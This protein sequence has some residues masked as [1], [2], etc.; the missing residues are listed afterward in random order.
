[1]IHQI[2]DVLSTDCR[3]CGARVPLFARFCPA[4]EAQNPLHKAAIAGAAALALLLAGSL[5]ALTWHALRTKEAP[6]V[7]T[8]SPPA[9]T[10][11]APADSASDYGWLVQAMADCEEEGK[12]LP[13]TLS[14]LIVPL[15]K[16]DTVLPGW[17]PVPIGTA[18][19][20][21]VLLNSTDA[22]IGLRNSALALYEK[23]LAFTVSDQTTSTVYKWKPAVG[24]SALKTRAP[25]LE[26]VKLG[27]EIPDVAEGVEWG[28]T[29]KMDRGTCY[30]INPLIRTPARSG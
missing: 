11:P 17:A 2:S 25:G 23:S 14:F 20:S 13:D 27:F 4:C 21:V 15:S 19:N 1:M 22:L 29:L 10:G 24:V 26:N 30:W 18:G 6:Q 5:V 16:T 7:A 8:Q 3:S 28:P 9:G 12:R